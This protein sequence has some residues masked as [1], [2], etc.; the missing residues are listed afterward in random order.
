[1]ARRSTGGGFVNVPNI[2]KIGT[3][4][5]LHSD[6]DKIIKAIHAHPNVKKKVKKRPLLQDL[7]AA[8][9]LFEQRLP[10]YRDISDIEIKVSGRSIEDIADE[11]SQRVSGK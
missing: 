11:I 6:F 3:V 9:K 4:V 2:R 5:Y 8:K 7:K 10:L 1:M